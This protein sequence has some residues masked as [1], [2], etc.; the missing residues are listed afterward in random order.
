MRTNVAE[1][2]GKRSNPGSPTNSDVAGDGGLHS[3]LT[4][5]LEVNWTDVQVLSGPLRSMNV[6]ARLDCDIVVDGDQ[7]ERPG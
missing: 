6:R 7:V 1:D 2:G 5:A 4:I 3:D